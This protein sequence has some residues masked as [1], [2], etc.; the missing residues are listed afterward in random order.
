MAAAEIIVLGA[1]SASAVRRAAYREVLRPSFSERE[2]GDQSAVMPQEGRVVVVAAEHGEVLAVGVSDHDPTSGVTLLSYLA[3]RP[4][5]R[6]TGLGTTLLGALRQCWQQA[7][8]RLVLAEVHDP[9][10][11]ELSEGEDPVARLRFYRRN[12]FGLLTVPWVQP[13]LGAGREGGMLL[14]VGYGAGEGDAVDRSMLL[15][16]TKRYFAA[17][18][19]GVPTDAEFAELQRRL[20]EDRLEVVAIDRLEDVTPL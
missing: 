15:A 6:S 14:L 11:W 20:A 1:E 12:G 9:R 8:A 19:G 13:A 4:G 7:G 17:S 10:R 18:E 5:V 2:L 3:T 16:W